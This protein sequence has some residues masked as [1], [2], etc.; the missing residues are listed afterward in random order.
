VTTKHM[1]KKQ[2]YLLTPMDRASRPHAK[3]TISRCIRTLV[4][5]ENKLLRSPTIVGY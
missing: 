2:V 4:D 5:I 3:Y 1:F